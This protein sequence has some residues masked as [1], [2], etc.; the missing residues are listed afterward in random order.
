[1][2]TAENRLTFRVFQEL[3][4]NLVVSHIVTMALGIVFDYVPDDGGH[5]VVCEEFFA[6][7]RLIN[8]RGA[9]GLP[10]ILFGKHVAVDL[11]FYIVV[12]LVLRPVA[13]VI[14]EAVS[15]DGNHLVRRNT[16]SIGLAD[17]KSVIWRLSAHLIHSEAEPNTEELD[18]EEG[19]LKPE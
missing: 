17:Y 2:R 11:P 10:G 6:V 8:L 5:L 9:P 13:V 16:V 3:G 7:A 4:H 12:P 14:H 15:L 18:V 19:R 1:M